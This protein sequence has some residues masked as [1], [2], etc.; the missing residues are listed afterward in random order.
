MAYFAEHIEALFGGRTF[1]YLLLLPQICLM[2]LMSAASVR[3]A[4][5]STGAIE[6]FEKRCEAV[7]LGNI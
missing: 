4:S 1:N 5:F 6:G 7:V 2:A 3:P